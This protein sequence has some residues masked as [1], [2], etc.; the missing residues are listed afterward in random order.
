[1]KKINIFLLCLSFA[2][3][4][5]AQD[6]IIYY[7]AVPNAGGNGTDVALHFANLTG[8]LMQIGSVNLS[9]VYANGCGTYLGSSSLFETEWGQTLKFD[10]AYALTTQ[11]GGTTYNRRVQYG[12]TSPNFGSPTSVDI[13]ATPL[14]PVLTMTLNFQS[15][16]ALAFHF[17]TLSEN[18]ANEITDLGGN[19]ISYAFQE[20]NGALPVEW[21]DFVAYQKGPKEVMLEWTTAEEGSNDHFE[22]ERSLDNTFFGKIGEVKA[23]SNPQS[24]NFYDF[25]DTQVPA[26]ILYY[27]IKQID[28][29]GMFSYSEVRKV[30][31]NP[32]MAWE[33]DLYPNPANEQVNLQLRLSEESGSYSVRLLDMTGRLILQEQQTFVNGQRWEMPVDKLAEGLYQIELFRHADG[34]R[35]TRQF[36][37]Q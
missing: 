13:A 22:I 33:F 26:N 5:K 11:Y 37:K 29:D 25:P 15:N 23:T 17:E 12:N 14:N 36:V 30:V 32:D 21:L 2:T 9:A 35:M 4:L 20:L 10:Q 7:E 6:L 24:V 27:R 34:T 18:P 1:M 28:L 3:C 8:S 16:C 31:I 19:P